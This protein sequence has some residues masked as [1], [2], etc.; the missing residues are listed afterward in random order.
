MRSSTSE[1]GR[2]TDP[3]V[4]VWHLLISAFIRPAYASETWEE[5]ARGDTALTAVWELDL[6][7]G[8]WANDEEPTNGGMQ[9]QQQDADSA[10][11]QGGGATTKRHEINWESRSTTLVANDPALL[12]NNGIQTRLLGQDFFLDE[13]IPR[14]QTQDTFQSEF[15]TTCD[16]EK[17]ARKKI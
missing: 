2:R 9:R 14:Y 10:G 3:H 4:D 8:Q 16:K 13:E 7:W 1:E 11:L 12:S 17:V 6:I 5:G 15:G